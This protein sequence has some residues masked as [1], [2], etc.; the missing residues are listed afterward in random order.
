VADD[1]LRKKEAQAPRLDTLSYYDKSEPSGDDWLYFPKIEKLRGRP[2]VHIDASKY[3]ESASF[4]YPE[5]FAFPGYLGTGRKL[6]NER[7]AIVRNGGYRTVLSGV[8]GDEFMGGIPV[9]NAQ[10][11]DLIVQFKL[12]TLAKQLMA[13]SLVKRQ[14]WIQLLWRAVVDLL[15]PSLGQYFTKQ[16]KVEHWIRKDFAKRTRLGTQLLGPA[17]NFGLW[18]PTRSSHIAGVTAMARKMAKWS[19][20]TLVQEEIRYPYLD[21]NL[22]EFIISIPASQLLRPGERRSLMRRSLIGLVP[23]EVLSRRTK[24]FGARTPLIAFDRNLEGLQVAFDSPLVS[25]LGYVNRD[26]F[27]ETLSSTTGAKEIHI[28]R[29]ARAI[30]LEFWLRDLA[31]HKLLDI[32]TALPG[33]LK[34]APLTAN[35]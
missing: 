15:P 4:E 34:T 20:A 10:L 14:P 5:F 1:I 29:M 30:S 19:L 7:A 35:A 31:R 3:A 24:Q 6:N 9:P 8:G 13:W 32:P 33:P 17:Y 23:Q 26:R 11:G 21:Q 2:G 22:I 18:L 12:F 16:A 28:G 25:Y 27:L